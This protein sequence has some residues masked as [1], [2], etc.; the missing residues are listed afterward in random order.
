MSGLWLLTYIRFL[1]FPPHEEKILWKFPLFEDETDL[2]FLRPVDTPWLSTQPVLERITNKWKTV[3]EYFCTFVKNST[4]QN[5]KTA[6]KTARY[7]RIVEF[8]EP[9]K[10]SITYST[11]CW[12]IHLAKKTKS[13][14]TMFQREGP[15]VHKLFPNT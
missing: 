2:F 15:M 12:A 1:R 13:Y 5:K 14:L 9:S 6:R 11:I 4:H 3:P 8:L 10:N 7:K